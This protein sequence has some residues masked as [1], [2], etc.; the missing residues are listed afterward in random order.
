MHL[1]YRNKKNE[2]YLWIYEKR[3]DDLLH[4]SRQLDDG[5]NLHLNTQPVYSRAAESDILTVAFSI[6]AAS[7]VPSENT[8]V[9]YLF[10]ANVIAEGSDTI[11]RKH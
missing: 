7:C 4:I 9:G 3:A 11:S 8:H 1:K 6:H 10:N 2:S 5:S